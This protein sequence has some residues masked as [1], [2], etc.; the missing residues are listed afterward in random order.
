[1]AGVLEGRR[2]TT[3]WEDL[4]DFAA[5][6]PGI[7][8]VADRFVVDRGVMTAGG[9]SPAFDLM[10]A[11]IRTRYGPATALAVASV[12]VYDEAHRPSD[13]QP[14][15]SVGRMAAEEPRLAR[16]IRAMEEALERPLTV[17][18]IARRAGVAP[19]TLEVLFRARLGRSPAAYYAGLRLGA[20]ERM[21]ADTGLGLREIALR[22]GFSSL[23]AF[24]RAF[25]RHTGVTARAF[26]AAARAGDGG[27]T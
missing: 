24:S 14:Q 13:A 22:T 25:R 23:S 21:V 5:R 10:L 18:A 9:A 20:A 26:R 2:A 6:H 1:V 11:L 16:A 8:V 7:E 27:R 19:R 12:F 4:E 3:H 15:V 17:A